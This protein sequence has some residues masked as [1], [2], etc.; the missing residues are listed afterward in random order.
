MPRFSP[1]SLVDACSRPGHSPRHTR[2]H[3]VSHDRRTADLADALA[4]DD[5]A[6]QFFDTLAYTH[7]KEWARWI[8]DAKKADTRSA[9]VTKA[10]EALRAG[11]RT[12]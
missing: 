6:R 10:I 5:E 11:K 2:Q 7:R 4:H 3:E 9:R 8:E 12:R 1:G